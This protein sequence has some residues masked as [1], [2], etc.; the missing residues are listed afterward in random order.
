[1]DQENTSGK[2]IIGVLIECLPMKLQ[3]IPVAS[4]H[5]RSIAYLPWLSNW[6]DI[7]RDRFENG[8]DL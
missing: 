4:L 3:V 5:K 7:L 8:K 1:M 6:E 2:P